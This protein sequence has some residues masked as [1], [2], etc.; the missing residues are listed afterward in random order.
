MRRTDFAAPESDRPAPAAA[1]DFIDREVI[2]RE[3]EWLEQGFRRAE[4]ELSQL[5]AKVRALGLWAP[6]VPKDLGGMGLGLVDHALMGAVLGR[7]PFGH[8]IFGTQAPDA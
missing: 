4:P 3:R 2:P 5:R 8:F 6:Q 1:Q 7:S